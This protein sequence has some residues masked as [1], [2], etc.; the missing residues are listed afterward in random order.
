LQHARNI[1]SADF[2]SN[3]WR[4]NI[5]RSDGW[6]PVRW[7]APGSDVRALAVPKKVIHKDKL[8]GFIIHSE[9]VAVSVLPK[10]ERR[11]CCCDSPFPFLSNCCS[12]YYYC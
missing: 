1:Y 8:G 10:E 2:K 5:L 9:Q 4:L 11:L 3:G 6:E 7:L 12:F